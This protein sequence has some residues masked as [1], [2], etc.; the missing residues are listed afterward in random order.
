MSQ[1]A[2]MSVGATRMYIGLTTPVR[3]TPT[4]YLRSGIIKKL[5]GGTLEIVNGSSGVAGTG[6]IIGDSEI[7][8]FDGSPSIYLLATGSTVTAMFTLGTNP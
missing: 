4:N 7:F 3:F 1:E 5:A 2:I 6:Y 8:A